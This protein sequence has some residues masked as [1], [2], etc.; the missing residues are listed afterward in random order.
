MLGELNK[1]S[2]IKIFSVKVNLSSDGVNVGGAAWRSV[3]GT[4]DCSCCSGLVGDVEAVGDVL[5]GP[6]C[7]VVEDPDG[8]GDDCSGCC[9]L[10][11]GSRF[12]DG[13]AGGAG[14]LRWGRLKRSNGRVL[15]KSYE[16]I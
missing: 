10:V 15:A 2:V 4:G 11:V 3:L 9:W 1:E 5:V 8:V 7:V 16:N 6:G 13:L 12:A 14:W